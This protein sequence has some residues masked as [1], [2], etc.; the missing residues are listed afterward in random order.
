MKKIGFVVSFILMGSILFAQS[1]EEGKQFLNYERYESAQGVFQK[2]MAADPKSDEAIYWMGQTYLQN[3]DIV[4]TTSAKEL[5]QKALQADPNSPLLM[6]GI[7]QVE[8]QQGKTADAR[9]RFEA[10]INAA[11]KRDR[12]EI[13]TAVGRANVMT[14]GGDI[15]YGIDKLKQAAE[16]DKKNPD[17]LNLIGFGYWKLND[18]TNATIYYQQA[19]ALDPH[20]A[21]ASFM[22]GRIYETQGYGQEL[23][24][25]KYYN[26]AISQ[27][28]NFAPVY[29][30]LYTYYYQRDV[31]K[32]S[33]YLNKYI[34]VADKDSKNCY[35]QA[36][37]M[38]VSKKYPET[39]SQA[40][41]C[42]TSAGEKAFPNLFGLKA[43][44]YD[45]MG[46][47]ANAK[48]S[49]EEFFARVNPDN[50]G[51][52][53]YATYG[54]VLLKFPGSEAL[55]LENINKAIDMDTIPEKKYQYVKD[56][57]QSYIDAGNYAEAGKWY[58][59]ILSMN[60]DY[61]KTDLFYAG[62]NDYRGGNYVAAD[63]VFKLYQ[64]KYPS[65]V[66]GWY[67]GARAKEGIDTSGELGLA[68]PLY[69]KVI[70]IGDTTQDKS[71]M[72]DKLIPALRY[73]L[74][75]SYNVKHEVDSA[76]LYNDKILE[77]D[78][79]DPTALKTKEALS[80]IPKTAADS[81]ATKPKDSTE[82][83]Q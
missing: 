46:D 13:L 49:F 18:G 70:E 59:K 61:G 32:A 24:Y 69:M 77:I 22:I 78:P 67:L 64:D 31:N 6:V 2:L 66:Y 53:D 51:P 7:G 50:I 1:I 9:N 80:S 30:W 35:A 17:I 4:D 65:D 14:K 81:S 16:K 52:T 8:L 26:E 45:K 39:I 75:Y 58:G 37:L 71:S 83:K 44:A 5:Y 3:T 33:E 74:A 55:A 54:K 34:A 40:D 19:L 60:P 48:K 42:I 41:A 20:D 72:K 36:S 10:A 82:I 12:D 27:D 25:M 68:K 56:I 23:I 63:S 43:Y 29:Y 28:P 11:K 21:R 47:S 57:A 73:M 76:I 62:Y 15:L 79:A 38:Y